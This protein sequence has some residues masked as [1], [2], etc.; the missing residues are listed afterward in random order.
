MTTIITAFLHRSLPG[1]IHWDDLRVWN[2]E[3]P[4]AQPGLFSLV[5]SAAIA[6]GGLL[7]FTARG[8]AA[9]NRPHF[10]DIAP[11]S[12]FTY[13]SNNDFTGRKYF[14]QPMCG[15]VAILDFDNDGKAGHFLQ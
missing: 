15:G 14:Q 4:A 1:I 8:P 9:V 12:K 6:I 11:R 3:A 13:I 10:T 2:Y 5:A 7:L